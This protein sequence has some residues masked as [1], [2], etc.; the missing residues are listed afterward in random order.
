M[1]KIIKNKNL[2]PVTI[3][4]LNLDDSPDL[5]STDPVTSRGIASAITE[6]VGTASDALQEQIDD[7]AEKAGSGYTPK[8]PASVAALN[9]LTGQENGWLYTMTDAGTLTDGSLA[10][11]AGDTVAWDATNSVWY[12]TTE[13]YV[14]SEGT[15]T[16]TGKG[17]T[18]VVVQI[19]VYG[20][21]NVKYD[22]PNTWD[23]TGISSSAYV[24]IGGQY[25]EVTEEN[26]DSY[27]TFKNRINVNGM[28]SKLGTTISIDLTSTT[29]SFYMFL[30]AANGVNISIPYRITQKIDIA[31]K[32]D[33][34]NARE[35]QL[36]S[37]VVKPNYSAV[38]YA[39]SDN[40]SKTTTLTSSDFPTDLKKKFS[41]GVELVPIIKNP[42]KSTWGQGFAISDEGFV[43]NFITGTSQ[44]RPCVSSLYDTSIGYNKTVSTT[45]YITGDPHCNYCFWGT[46]KYE[47][48][49]KYPLLYVGGHLGTNDSSV[50]ANILVMRIVGD[51]SDIENVSFEI[52]QV[53]TFPASIGQV[54]DVQVIGGNLYA[55]FGSKFTKFSSLPSL[56]DGN[57]TF[58]DSDILDS[59]TIPDVW[60][61]TPIQ[62]GC[63]VDGIYYS[64]HGSST[65]GVLAIMDVANR[66]GKIGVMPVFGEYEA[67][68]YYMN[69]FYVTNKIT[70]RYGVAQSLIVS[71]LS[72][73][74]D[75]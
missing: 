9:G 75:A 32:G 7:I 6:A 20:E 54:A 39:L 64:V 30:R 27:R 11:V 56:S 40:V 31:E 23:L 36:L 4:D 1:R 66:T 43:I 5:N 41:N 33:R 67:L 45:G 74:F 51:F 24:C 3:A 73:T 42:G 70:N 21:C 55:I 34:S 52:V 14:T 46:E 48:A 10:V 63:V 16:F 22:I 37:K 2:V 58:T 13:N 28:P 57:V 65:T 68:F 18:A 44:A 47:A 71:K 12:K 61:P 17:D 72:F 50:A 25:N 53:V 8:G 19:P 60:T 29:K 59:F 69:N 26:S 35:L 49:D 15:I 38:Q 62:S